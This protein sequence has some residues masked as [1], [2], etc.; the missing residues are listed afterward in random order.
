MKSKCSNNAVE[1]PEV[2]LVKQQWP[3]N[4]RSHLQVGSADSA[5]ARLGYDSANICVLIETYALDMAHAQK[6]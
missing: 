1:R 3:Q 4:R 5:R 2:V 6:D